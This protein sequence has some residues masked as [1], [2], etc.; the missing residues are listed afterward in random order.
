MEAASAEAL[1]PTW[2]EVL[3]HN[4]SLLPDERFEELEFKVTVEGTIHENLEPY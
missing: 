3:H 1:A 4:G 2:V